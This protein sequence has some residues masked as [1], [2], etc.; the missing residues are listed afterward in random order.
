MI[1]C[2]T[3]KYHEYFISHDGEMD[4]DRRQTKPNLFSDENGRKN[5]GINCCHAPP[6]FAYGMILF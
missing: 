4:D 1:I 5:S 2:N 3:I 6:I